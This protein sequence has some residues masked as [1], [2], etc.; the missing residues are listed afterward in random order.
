MIEEFIKQITNDNDI[1]V[2]DHRLDKKFWKHQNKKHFYQM[3]ENEKD[4]TIKS[5]YE[6]PRFSA[7]VAKYERLW[8]KHRSTFN[9]ME[10]ELIEKNYMK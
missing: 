7:C 10:M 2:M 6:L 1:V 8:N 5:I 3:L 9:I 4:I